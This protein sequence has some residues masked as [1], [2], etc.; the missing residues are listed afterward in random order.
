MNGNYRTGKSADMNPAELKKAIKIAE[1]I[2]ADAEADRKKQDADR[3]K[4]AEA[5]ADQKRK[6]H[7]KKTGKKKPAAKA[8]KKA[9][10]AEQEAQEKMIRFFEAIANYYNN[11]KRE[12]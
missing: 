6:Q 2:L 11:G 4:A 7:Q 5:A 10:T 1:T 12:G 8:P 9:K 3:K